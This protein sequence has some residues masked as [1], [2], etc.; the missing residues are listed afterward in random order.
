MTSPAISS[1][2]SSS[3]VRMTW[4]TFTEEAL[5]GAFDAIQVGHWKNA[6]A[7]VVVG[8]DAANLLAG[9]FEFFHGAKAE[10]ALDSVGPDG[11]VSF[12]VSSTG[13]AAD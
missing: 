5:R 9:A 6:Q 10:I 13:Y 2:L 3:A 1:V 8:C 11:A 4:G 12:K 7:G